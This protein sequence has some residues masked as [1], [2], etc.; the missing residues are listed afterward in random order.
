MNYIISVHDTVKN[1]YAESRIDGY[2]IFIKIKVLKYYCNNNEKIVLDFNGIEKIS[3]SFIKECI[4]RLIEED[5]IDKVAMYL[6]LDNIQNEFMK[7]LITL[8]MRLAQEKYDK[9]EE[10]E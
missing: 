7:N 9:K 3:C 5:G 10:N 4:G 8:S 1:K 6:A 2:N